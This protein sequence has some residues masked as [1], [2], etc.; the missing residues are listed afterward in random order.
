[1]PLEGVSADEWVVFERALIIRD[2]FTGGTRTFTTTE[3]ARE[4][5]AEVYR[6]YGASCSKSLYSAVLTTLMTHEMVLESR[7][8]N[9]NTPYVV[10]VHLVTEQLLTSKQASDG[11]ETS[12]CCSHVA[13]LSGRKDLPLCYVLLWFRTSTH[14][15]HSCSQAI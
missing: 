4:F 10:W 9:N 11:H 13:K 2:L 1:M 3:D 14:R 5:R 7:R 15:P 6:H 8:Q 12:I